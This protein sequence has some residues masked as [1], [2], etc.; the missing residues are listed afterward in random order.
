MTIFELCQVLYSVSDI[1][2]H[3]EATAPAVFMAWLLVYVY[4]YITKRHDVNVQPRGEGSIGYLCACDV[5]TSTIPISTTSHKHMNTILSLKAI[6]CVLLAHLHY[7]TVLSNAETL[8][9]HINR[10]AS[11]PSVL[12]AALTQVCAP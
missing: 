11:P 8:L 12:I 7:T 9:S 6:G 2:T 1:S 3:M 10:Y 5:T 4:H